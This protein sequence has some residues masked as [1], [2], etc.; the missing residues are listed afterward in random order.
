MLWEMDRRMLSNPSSSLPLLQSLFQ[1]YRTDRTISEATKT[2]ISF[3]LRLPPPP[4]DCKPIGKTV[5]SR[6][7]FS[8]IPQIFETFPQ[9]CASRTKGVQKLGGCA[10]AHSINIRNALQRIE[11]KLDPIF[12]NYTT[13]T[14]LGKWGMALMMVLSVLLGL[15]LSL[16]AIFTR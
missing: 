6:I 1:K 3:S 7:S 10:R 14:R 15:I 2:R 8:T 13:A 5:N 16:K 4:I 9:T 11:I 12:D